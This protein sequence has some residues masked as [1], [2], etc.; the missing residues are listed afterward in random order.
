[1]KQITAQGSRVAILGASDKDDR[2]AKK[3]FDLLRAEGFEPVPVHPRLTEI[4]GI[5]VVPSL[6]DI[7]GT[8]DTLTLYVNPSIVGENAQAIVALKPRRVIMNPGTE[9]P[10]VR[11]MLEEKGIEVLEA[12]TLVLLKTGQF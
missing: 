5:P 9:S 4:E 11:V 10:E 2:Y 3:A 7:P 6:T 12:C 8:I 1:M